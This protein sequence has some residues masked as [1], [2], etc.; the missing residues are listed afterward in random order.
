VDSRFG[1]ERF[2]Y[3]GAETLAATL[4]IESWLQIGDG[5]GFGNVASGA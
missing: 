2:T 1:L 5:L 4:N 3:D